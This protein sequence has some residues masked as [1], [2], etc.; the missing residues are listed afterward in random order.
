M[1]NIFKDGQKIS[2]LGAHGLSIKADRSSSALGN[3]SWY[4]SNEQ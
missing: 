1:V 4:D 3:Y 2:D